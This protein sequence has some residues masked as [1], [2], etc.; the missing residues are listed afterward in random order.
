M[1]KVTVAEWLSN[2]LVPIPIDDAC[3]DSLKGVWL[4]SGIGVL[5]APQFAII[6][7]RVIILISRLDN[8]LT[9]R[10]RFALTGSNPVGDVMFFGP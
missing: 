3:T 7:V 9:L 2:F 6:W 5:S 1:C 4:E 8:M 10:V